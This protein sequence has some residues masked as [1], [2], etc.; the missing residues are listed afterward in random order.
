MGIPGAIVV[1][2]RGAACLLGDGADPV[3]GILGGFGA[4]AMTAFR[5]CLSVLNS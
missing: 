5:F 2:R 3:V 1:A 4:G